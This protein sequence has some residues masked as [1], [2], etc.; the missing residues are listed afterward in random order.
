MKN[1][2]HNGQGEKFTG[3]ATMG[4]A[5]MRMM[6]QVKIKVM[7]CWAVLALISSV[8]A[9]QAEDQILVWQF[10]D[11]K[12]GI[13]EAQASTVD[14][15]GNLIIT[16]YT[17]TAGNDDFYTI[18]V[19]SLDH[20]VLWAAR[21]DH[22]QGDDWAVAVAVDG[23]DD[24]IVAGH[25]NNGV[26]TDIAVIKYHGTTGI[27]VWTA[28]YV[29]N[30]PA[31]GDDMPRALA[32]DALNNIY[33]A[34]Y[35][36][37]G[38]SAG[39]D[40]ILF[41][42]GPDGPN[43][44]GTPF[45]QVHFDGS[46]HNNDRFNSISIGAGGVAVAGYSTVMHSGN[47]Q[48][49]DY[50]TMKFDSLGN[51][52]WQMTYDS[53]SDNDQASY[54]GMDTAGNV[55]VTGEAMSGGQ[56][57]MV[58]IK[59]AAADGAQ[60]WITP[61]S[62][63]T[64]NSPKGLVVDSDNEVYLIG[65]TFTNSG[66]DDFYTARYA[67]GDGAPVWE[68]VFDSGNSNSDMPQALALD[69]T[70]GLY[71]TGH[72]HID[73]TGDD[74]FQ[75]LKYNKANG[76]QIWQ[77]GPPVGGN[78]QP[79]GVAVAL[80][81]TADG[82]VYVAGWS[83]PTT[84]DVD[85]FA[86]KY[87]ADLMN[88]PTGL[89]ATV[90]N[91]TCVSLS[92]QD[93]SSSPNED[94]FCIERCQGFACNDFTELTC[95][96]GRDQIAY[97][98][99]SVTA[100]TWYSYR[101][102]GKSNVLAYSLPSP[103]ASVLTT[104]ID[105]PAPDWLYVYP[106]PLLPDTEHLDD[107]AFAIAAGKDNNPV[108]TGHSSTSGSQY[109]YY[110]VK[111]DR[112]NASTPFWVDVY[113]DAD[114]QGDSGVC[115]A[116][117]NNDDVAVSGFSSVNDGHGGNTNVI[118]TIKYAKTG[119][120]LNNSGYPLWTAEYMGP[121]G[122]YDARAKAVAA[123]TDGG[124]FM[125]VTGHG[126]NSA[127]NDDIYLIKYKPDYD[128]G[129]QQ[130]W[131]ITPFDGGFND[132]PTATA[133]TSTGDVV[134]AGIT[135]NAAGNSDVFLSKYRGTD[136]SRMSG[137]PYIH[138]FGHGADAI[139]ALAV[140]ADGSIYVAG[141]AMNAAGNLDIYVNKF[142][143]GGVP[144]W[145]ESGKIIDGP[146][147]DFDEAVAIAID[148]NDGEIVVGTTITSASGSTDFHL[149]RYQTDGT[150]R[151]QKTLDQADHD[152]V[153]VAMALSPSGEIC[154][155]GET[156]NGTYTDALAVKYD[157]AGNLIGSTKFD[158][159][160]DDTVT[161]ITAN[162]L[163]EFYI[164]GY[165]KTGASA[166]ADYD[167]MVFRLYGPV[168]IQAPSPF[169]ATAHNS[170][171]DL[172]WTE[173]DATG[174]GFKLYRKTGGCTVGGSVFEQTDLIQTL[175]EMDEIFITDSALNI[176]ATYCYGVAAYRANGEMSRI[177]E[178]QVTTSVPVP[179]N[180]VVAIARNTS[181][182]EVCWHDNSASEDGF[183]VERCT[184]ANCDFS[185]FV[186]MLAPAENNGAA[187]QT[188]FVDTTAC[189]SGAG[190]AFRYRVQA[191][192]LNEWS[193]GFDGVTDTVTTLGLQAPSSLISRK[194]TETKVDLQWLD[195]TVDESDFVI[196][197]CLGAGCTDFSEVGA[198][199][200]VRGLDLYLAM[201]EP[202]WS[203]TPGEIID[204]SGKDRHA[205][206][207]AGATT[208]ADSYGG[209][210]NS[211]SGRLDGYDDY[212]ATPL[213]VDQSAGVTMMAWVKPA[214]VD[215]RWGYLFSTEDG[216]PTQV[217]NNWGIAR[218]YSY[219]YVSTGGGLINTGAQVTPGQWQHLAVVFSPGDAAR[220]YLNGVLV[221]TLPLSSGMPS[222]NLF[223]GRQGVLNQNFFDGLVDEVAVYNRALTPAEIQK[224]EMIGV[225]PEASGQRW[226]TDSTVDSKADYQYRITARKQTECGTDLS[227]PSNAIVVGTAPSPPEPLTATL[228]K[229]GVI[230]L[231]WTPQT[232]IQT[233][234]KLEG[235]NGA[236][237]TDFV[238]ITSDIGATAIK[239]TDRRACYGSDGVNRYR[240][241][242]LGPWGESAPSPI[243]EVVSVAGPA[244]ANLSV[245]QVTEAS[246]ALSWTYADPNRD[247]FIIE[248][249][250]GDQATC[251]QNNAN[252]VAVTG[253]PFSGQDSAL[254][255]YWRM[256]DSPWTGAPGE[257]ID[258]SGKGYHGTAHNGAAQ[259][260]PGVTSYAAA[261]FDGGDDSISTDLMIDQSSTSP[262]ATFMAWVYPTD[263]SSRYAYLLSTDNGGSDWGLGTYAYYWLIDAGDTQYWVYDY[264]GMKTN[265]WMHVAVVFDPNTG[266]QFYRDGVLIFNS[267]AIDFDASTAP[268]TIGGHPLG[269]S[270]YAGK[271]DEVTVFNRPLSAQE[272]T[273]YM[274]GS[275]PV[276]VT[277]ANGIGTGGTYTY[278]VT[279]LLNNTTCGDWGGMTS[280]AEVVTSTPLA[281]IAPDGLTVTRNSS[282]ELDL[283]WKANTSSESGFLIERCLGS[284][285]DFSTLT[286]VQVGP[287]V[288]TYKDTSVCQGL[289]Y[290]YR[291]KAVKGVAAPWEWETA[292]AA[293]FEQSTAV[294]NAVAV[295]LNVMNESEISLSWDD[296]NQDEDA[297]ELSRC[298]V[299]PGSIACDQ[300]D[301][302][303]SIKNFPGSVN[304][305]LL[306]YRM[307]ET[308]WVGNWSEV[309]DA[310]GRNN[311]GV[312]YSGAVTVGDGRF[313]R[314]GSFNGS[315]SFVYTQ[316]L[317][318][319]GRNSPGVTMEAWVNPTMTD[320]NP[321]SVLSTENGG[322]DWGLIVQNG[323]WY[324]STGLSLYDTGLTADLN[325]WQHVTALFIPRV[326]IKFYKNDEVVT[327]NEIDYD[328][329]TTYLN[330]GRN[331]STSYAGYYFQGRIDE[332][333]I[334]DRPLT[335]AEVAAH[336]T[337]Q[338]TVNFVYP[339]SGLQ[340][341]NV[342][343]YR[344]TAKK[345]A[346]CGWNEVTTVSGTTPPPPPPTNLIET[347]IDSTS[348]ALQWND[349]NGS[350]TGYVVSRCEGTDG[351]CVAPELMKQNL[352]ANS[353]TFTDNT[354]CPQHT[355]TYRVWAE[356]TWGQTDF[357]ERRVTTLAQANAPTNLAANAASE[358]KI[359]VSWN[360]DSDA[361]DETGVR[362]SRCA[363]ADC[364][365]LNLP[366]G[367][368]DY[369]DN[370]LAP[371]TEYCYQVSVY[372]TAA[373]AWQ[374]AV[375]GP[376]CAR[377]STNAGELLAAPANTTKVNL[378]WNDNAQTETASVIERCD[379]DLATCCSGG[380]T[381]CLGS[382]ATVGAVGTNLRTFADESVC[383]GN[384]YTYRV[385]TKGEGLASGNGGCWKKRAPLTFTSF[386]AF[387]GVEVVI[388]YQAEMKADFTDIRFYDANAHREL[389]FWV[390]E[391]SDSSSATVWLMTGSSPA[392]YLYY[393]NAVAKD[394]G[395][396]DA[397]F[398]DT[399]DF[400]GTAIDSNKWVELDSSDKI[401]QNNGLQFVYR[402]SSQD[403]AVVSTKTFER[404]AGNELFVDLTVGA[405][406]QWDRYESFFLGWEQDQVTSPAWSGNGAHLLNLTS[407]GNH[408]MQYVYEDAS[409]IYFPRVLYNDLTR[410]QVKIVLNGG[411]G[412]KYYLRGGA[413]PAW[414]LLTE[415]TSAM[416]DDDVL[417]VGFH[418][419][420]HNITIHQVTV[421]HASAQRG[422]AVNFAGAEGDGVICLSF[423]HTWVGS[424][425]S[426]AAAVVPQVSP[427]SGLT[428]SVVDGSVQL[429][430]S[431]GSGD[432]SDFL[433]ERD[434]GGG[435]GQVGSVTAG[436]NTYSDHSMSAS[437]SCRYQ[438]KG[439]KQS[440]CPW[441]SDPSAAVQLLSP[442]IGPVVNAIAENAFQIRLDWNDAADE[443]GY[444]IETQVLS[445]AWMPV[446]TL[447]AN[448]VT[449]TDNH[450]INP[451]TRYTYRVRA[452]RTT[453][454]S[455]WGQNSVTTPSYTPGAATCPV[456]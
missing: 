232:T 246:A 387:A 14:S 6:R 249:C 316:L 383:A 206:A 307:D 366:P 99:C 85:Y 200:S 293:P 186:T 296:V 412:A 241:K 386:P 93:N 325:T 259:D 220:F 15:D 385:S 86:V 2:A 124:N 407:Q 131:A 405:D 321:R 416:P 47:R 130:V 327:I 212:L 395:V 261:A 415:T 159:G 406:Y 224:L 320:G 82:N 394:G 79:V 218:N 368:S 426:A 120:D 425:T 237:C 115:L 349:N 134:V 382:F 319:Q 77:Q 89:T 390:K 409:G 117:D 424:S 66:K 336:N 174:D 180:F 391:K 19:S 148:P 58:T 84:N 360:Y 422:A 397:L 204:Y 242:A 260:V 372:K 12:A 317:I 381:S 189:D 420:G 251:D 69:R 373:C 264:Y 435:Y 36:N 167:F 334:Y 374:T 65:D 311:H 351:G 52:L 50:L 213:A 97:T 329:S 448:Q 378:A 436:I 231:A 369:A 302:F 375:T 335:E 195:N 113:D 358:V 214:S 429:V 438:V 59:Y 1:I 133:F 333:L 239:F 250:A 223:I 63:G 324:V 149:L 439:H 330:I 163:G 243:A 27:P 227:A 78:Q 208:V 451:S 198:A 187:A 51:L 190:K 273:Q 8:S 350:E 197:R 340:P 346:G 147:S 286:S 343:Y 253:S 399:Y 81:V 162:R 244:P 169:T 456:P 96:I 48:D 419:A 160:F 207:F 71:V 70:G 401:S 178:R 428:A 282:T 440:P 256:E 313:G 165:F 183:M 118:Y 357:I 152:E 219:W 136:G 247:G 95:G 177:S 155:A 29:L 299:V 35:S 121:P 359:D 34:G 347:K 403:A 112:N 192:R 418:Q 305:A 175:P 452:R 101:V 127:G 423:S 446:A 240:I 44:D 137:W 73:A 55:I 191:Y 3:K 402:N 4:K 338:E 294:A 102:K 209:Y 226:F 132:Y 64:H 279:P 157:Y 306:H 254:Q 142:N 144:Q 274:Q 98:D 262:G 221:N 331:A 32:V 255:A 289:T 202:S 164:A 201:N 176:G 116:L 437:T 301:Q 323:K 434:C 271:M 158:H 377:T 295:T 129:D 76:N 181:D 105:F 285:C 104:I 263:R 245:N 62:A 5:A 342:Y 61:Y 455:A 126:K 170:S 280:A 141:Y 100:D 53:G 400:Q 278:R 42:L 379:G 88:A 354:L 16:G 272:V 153:L 314:A 68:R 31:N 75:T 355:Y 352:F 216:T 376:V 171:V 236:G 54:V 414:R 123:A 199:S 396:T 276:N 80:G 40:G 10:Q 297:Y 398:T 30:G 11:A 43:P 225:F 269:G 326:G 109:D 18:K 135:Y 138:D 74:D 370:E 60:S 13:Q 454:N 205:T 288:T 114:G 7:I 146:G 257:V 172:S 107:Q 151:W 196:E 72:T 384:A 248:R 389:Q 265:A 150:L 287:G 222:A 304:G 364:V 173:N 234:F 154:L 108:A 284:G 339:D 46:A 184:G 392:I 67:G 37:S 91:Q 380:T 179:P 427:P 417:R 413:Y 139:K 128:G 447:P 449:F 182:V 210:D 291:V 309:Q 328:L 28:P 9:V 453:G 166:Q 39:D 421:K 308:S 23:N 38:S 444:D 441:T 283:A 33:V 356:G 371:N 145:G 281:P 362:L 268:F 83:Q 45:W 57:N 431:P 119:P 22:P 106:D 161:A 341:E 267:A 87:K 103:Q 211:G 310:S 215:G 432:E 270:N 168:Q 125:A 393:G 230:G 217:H 110:T 430:W 266:V 203:A 26:N 228:I 94:N 90:V 348:C 318:D 450:G 122:S 367:T 292:Y 408:Y 298:L 344:V 185:Q 277:D 322:N 92:W 411:G 312:A 111:L 258:S 315:T 193:S 17:D 229:P 25:I 188:C 442:P 303:A 140:A 21:Y 332:V 345:A 404:A 235:C 49:Y 143:E 443:E 238:E 290:R 388:P 337:Y 252:F 361:S 41:K 445:G 433:V 194:V 300:A 365:D 233:G 353:T 20:T 410:Y 363:G 56:Q 156:E 24:V 275:G